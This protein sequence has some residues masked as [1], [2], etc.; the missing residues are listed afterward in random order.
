VVGSFINPIFD[1]MLIS[2]AGFLI[3]TMVAKKPFQKESSHCS[4][5]KGATTSPWAASGEQEATNRKK[6]K[7]VV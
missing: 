6:S 5:E 2:F 1:G 4:W 7:G 3:G